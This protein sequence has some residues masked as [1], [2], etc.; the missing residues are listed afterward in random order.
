[1]HLRSRTSTEPQDNTE[2]TQRT[3]SDNSKR[4]ERTF[5]KK[6]GNRTKRELRK[7]P[8]V[9]PGSTKE[10]DDNQGKTI[11]IRERTPKTQGKI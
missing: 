2:N 11:T 4:T 1:M 8:K 7:N 9:T 3:F 10:T 5:S 6:N